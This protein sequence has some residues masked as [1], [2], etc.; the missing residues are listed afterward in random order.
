MSF[1]LLN[2]DSK[3]F[4]PK[5]IGTSY[6]SSL[7]IN[8]KPYIPKLLRKHSKQNSLEKPK[9]MKYK[10]YFIIEEDDKH[11]YKFDFNYMI[12]FEN[13]GICQETKLLSEDVL[14]QLE[15]LKIVELESHI[16]KK[17]KKKSNKQNINISNSESKNITKEII[18]PKK[19]KKQLDKEI[20]KDLIKFKIIEYLNILTVDNYKTILNEIYEI[21]SEKVKNQRKFLDILFNKSIKEK[22]FMNLYAKLFKDLDNILPQR[23]IPKSDDDNQI[24]ISK[25][26]KSASLMKK[27]LLDKCGKI[28]TI[29]LNQKISSYFKVHDTIERDTK[30]KELILG[31]ANF[32]MELIN[33]DV[34]PIKMVFEYVDDLL[35]RI[36][37]EK[38][39]K[40]LKMIYL[41]TI[42]ILLDK[43]G[44]LLKIKENKLKEEDKKSF[45][46]NIKYYLIKLEEIN[47][48]EQ[49]F[50][51]Y[52][53]YKI[54][55]LKERS[56]NNWE[57][58]KFEKSMYNIR[59]INLEEEN[60]IEISNL[61]AYTQNEVTVKMSQDLIKFKE[62]ILEDEGTPINYDWSIVENIYCEHGNT[63]AE[64]I[65][66]FL[67]SC[68]DFVQ[69]ENN[70]NL[71]KDYFT[72]LIFYYKKSLR[73]SEK[74]D[75]VKKNNTTFKISK[76]E[77]FR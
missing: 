4:V 35:T 67:F 30:I 13:W 29:E 22:L 15:K 77:F 76:K 56:K 60:E 49:G 27:E 36:N 28:F 40:F 20:K 70:L 48:K 5:K 64:M 45:N 59:K 72:E 65:Q 43:F 16:G 2:I 25:K 3:S 11:I 19:F 17:G 38:E 9:S 7:N 31:N 68:I 47:E 42:I 1:D 69:N 37:E 50:A 74:K 18:S 53:K 71:A 12:S 34:L 21:I 41:E 52:I 57:Q 24:I 8:A 46:E 54:I 51:Q 14:N 55:N 58:S 66:G 26:K 75:I 39:D 32:V 6:S 33:I 23:Y 44:T 63:V 61:K 10:E 73:N 62:H